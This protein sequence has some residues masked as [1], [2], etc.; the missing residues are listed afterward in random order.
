MTTAVAEVD[1]FV[2]ALHGKQMR[3]IAWDFDNT[4]TISHHGKGT[5]M[6]ALMHDAILQ[7]VRDPLFMATLFTRLSPQFKLCIASFQDHLLCDCQ[8]RL[9]GECL[10][11]PYMHTV[12]H[13]PLDFS[14]YCWYPPL[15][16]HNKIMTPNK[17]AHLQCIL[18]HLQWQDETT[19]PRQIM[20]IDDDEGNVRMAKQAGF[21]AFCLT[22]TWHSNIPGFYAHIASVL[23]RPLATASGHWPPP[24]HR[25][26]IF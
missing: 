8:H 3:A 14:Y 18:R 1:A 9:F 25:D 17:N 16:C 4:L 12:C 5:D 23:Q 19:T 15:R 24:F 22:P 11:R 26:D 7:D 2:H 20:L 10:I 6:R 21:R 13:R